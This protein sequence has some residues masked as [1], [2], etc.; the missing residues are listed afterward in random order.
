VLARDDDVSNR[1]IM[2]GVATLVL[3]ENLLFM[4]GGFGAFAP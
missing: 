2:I 4:A 3:I 1:R